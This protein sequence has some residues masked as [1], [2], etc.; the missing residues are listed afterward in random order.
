[1]AGPNIP[2]RAEPTPPTLA[3]PALD[4]ARTQA[5]DSAQNAFGRAQTILT[6]GQGVTQPGQLQKKT[7]LGIGG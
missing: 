6:G 2:R 4:A 3:N 1:M 5:L 7:L